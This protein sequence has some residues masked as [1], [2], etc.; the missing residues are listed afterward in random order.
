MDQQADADNDWYR[1]TLAELL[2]LLEDRQV[3]PVVAA[4]VPLAQVRRSHQLLEEGGH[5]GKFVLVTDAY[6]TR[7]P[8]DP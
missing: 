5:P 1:S 2:A 8:D 6:T 7:A 4:R 3:E